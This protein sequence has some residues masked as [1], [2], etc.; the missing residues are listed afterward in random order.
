[1]IG[2]KIRE[3]FTK[4]VYIQ[5]DPGK[6]LE[7]V[8]VPPSEKLVLGVQVAVVSIAGLICLE[9]AHM[10]FMGTWNSEIFAAIT[11]LIGTVTG[12]FLGAKA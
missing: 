9:I 2:D 3:A 6:K 1:M 7:K 5:K 8:E 11:G 10:A 12:I 4:T